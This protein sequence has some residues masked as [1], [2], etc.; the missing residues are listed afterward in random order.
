MSISDWSTTPALNNSAP[1]N[2]APEGMVPGAVNDIMRQMMAD[3]RVFYDNTPVKD[4][5]VSFGALTC[6]SLTVAG[7]AHTSF[8]RRDAGNTFVGAQV[9]E[10]GTNCLTLSNPS[11]PANN[12]RWRIGL[13]SASGAIGLYPETDAGATSGTA[14]SVTR[15]GNAVTELQLN[16]TTTISGVNI[17]NAG[18][19]NAGT[20]ANARIAQ[21]NV[22]QHQAALAINAQQVV[23]PPT[24]HSGNLTLNA[25]YHERVITMSAAGVITVGNSHGFALGDSAAFVRNTPGTVT[26]AASGSQIIRSPGSRLTIPEQYGT[27]VLTYIATNTWSLSGV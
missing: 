14:W 27:A 22:T 2:G 3:I 13:V 25:D 11:A 7:I 9:I 17:R 21:S 19:I 5:D 6:A 12:R 8:A 18:L 4:G 16:A 20:F 10:G 15:S 24:N 1:P 23:S 26:F